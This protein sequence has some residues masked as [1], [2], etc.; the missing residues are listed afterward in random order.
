MWLHIIIVDTDAP[1]KSQPYS[2]ASCA[3]VTGYRVGGITIAADYDTIIDAASPHV[4]PNFVVSGN[5]ILLY[6]HYAVM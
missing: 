3:A 5:S 1:Q 2:A 4:D 6:G